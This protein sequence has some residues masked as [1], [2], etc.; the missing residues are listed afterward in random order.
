MAG[1]GVLERRIEVE[2]GREGRFYFVGSVVTHPSARLQGH[3]RELFQAVD[4]LAEKD[5]IDGIVLW[6]SQIGFYEKLGFFLGGLQATWTP[7]HQ[8][9]LAKAALPVKVLKSPESDFTA[10]LYRAHEMRRCAVRRSFEEMRLLWKIPE[11]TIATTGEAYALLGKGED[12]QNVIHEWAGPADHVLACIDA[13][14]SINPQARI[15]SPG[16][17]HS[18]DEARVVSSF[19]QESFE[20]RLE[21]LGLFKPLSNLFDR[22]SMDPATLKFPFFI[23]GLDSI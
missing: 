2:E 4:T 9:P 10:K 20:C 13:L 1:L 17:L 3:Q 7:T 23:W 19:E 22:A 14:R 21:Y 18:D 12:F 8:R 16:V 6:S 11:M 15:L 5:G